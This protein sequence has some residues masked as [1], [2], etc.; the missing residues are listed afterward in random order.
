MANDSDKIGLAGGKHPIDLFIIMFLVFLGI[1]GALALPDGHALRVILA[2]PII[3]FYPGYALVSL[4]W[5]QNN[6]DGK[7]IDNL[8]RI[9]LSIGLSIAIVSI[10]G[11]LLSLADSL[12]LIWVLV[13]N[14]IALLA[15]VGIAYF[16]RS[17]LPQPK[18][19][20]LNLSQHSFPLSGSV[21]IAMT[22][23]IVIG[24]VICS[25]FITYTI[26]KPSIAEPYTNFYIYDSNMT[27]QNYP[28]N[29]TVNETAS[30]IVGIANYEQTTV[31]YTIIAGIE[32]ASVVIYGNNWDNATMLTSNVS[33]GRNITM[34][35]EAEFQN[36]F[37]FI[38][39]N[40]GI[41]KVVWQLQIEGLDTDYELHL[42]IKVNP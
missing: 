37:S 42:W 1:A 33:T 26:V 41:Y 16:R 13:G 30:V 8:E 3:I 6:E 34:A 17:Q 15:F 10:I 25:G 20:T 32:N 5:P 14:L 19:Y 39:S 12:N 18:R 29:I 31:N 28:L 36:K 21:E 9:A 4:L 23:L 24:I 7:S 2:I 27:M 38:F 11:L 22:I 35:H 40:P